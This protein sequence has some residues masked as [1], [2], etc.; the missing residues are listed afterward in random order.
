VVGLDI[1]RSR[2]THRLAALGFHRP[3]AIEYANRQES[4]A[5]LF[6]L[7]PVNNFWIVLRNFLALV[8]GF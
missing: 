1:E 4:S 3:A 8:T 7:R 2:P 6:Q 5:S